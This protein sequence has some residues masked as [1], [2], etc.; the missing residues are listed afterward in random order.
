MRNFLL[1][2]MAGGGLA[3][4]LLRVVA[5]ANSREASRVGLSVPKSCG[6]AVRRTRAQRRLRAFAAGGGILT[7]RSPGANRRNQKRRELLARALQAFFRIEGDPIVPQDD[8]W[9]TRFAITDAT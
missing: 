6:D 2:L 9:R 7:W 8:G 3:G 1:F 5:A 4:R